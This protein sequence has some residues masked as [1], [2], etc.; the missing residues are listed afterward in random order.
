MPEKVMAGWYQRG[1]EQFLF[2]PR[3]CTAPGKMKKES[4]VGKPKVT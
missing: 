2:V 1:Y 3:G 4:Q